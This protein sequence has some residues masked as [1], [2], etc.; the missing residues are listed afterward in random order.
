MRGVRLQ[1]EHVR[2]VRLQPD[3]CFNARKAIELLGFGHESIRM[4]GTHDDYRMNVATLDAAIRQDRTNGVQPIAVIAS[5]GTTNTGAFVP[6]EAGLVLVRSADAM[7][8]AFSLVPP[9]LRT[10]GSVTGVGGLPWLSEYGFQQTRGF[11]ALKVWMAITHI[12]LSGYQRTIEENLGLARY[13]ADRIRQ[14]SELAL[15]ATPGLSVVCFRFR[16]GS[17]MKTS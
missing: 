15:M 1:P 12:G 9:Y 2:G 6:V 11:R 17:M 16:P 14:A 3:L 7:R 13:L 4:I 8:S 5:A 10:D